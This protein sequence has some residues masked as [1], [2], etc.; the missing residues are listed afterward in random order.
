MIL[1]KLHMKKAKAHFLWLLLIC[2]IVLME[3]PSAFS[4]S[5]S[6]KVPLNFRNQPQGRDKGTLRPGE[7]FLILKSTANWVKIKRRNGQVGW[8]YRKYVR[9]DTPSKKQSTKSEAPESDF[10]A[11]KVVKA[12]SLNVRSGA[13]SNYR[14]V[15][16][17]TNDDSVEVLS[18]NGGWSKIRTSNGQVGYVFTQYLSDMASDIEDTESIKTET[19]S[20]TQGSDENKETATAE[21]AIEEPAEEVIAESRTK[22]DSTLEAGCKDCLT[23]EARITGPGR[24]LLDIGSK[25]Y[26]FHSKEQAKAEKADGKY[27]PLIARNCQVSSTSKYGMRK[28]PILGTRLMHTG[29]DI[30]TGGVATPIRAPMAGKIISAGR[31]GGYGNQIKMKLDNGLVISFSHLSRFGIKKGQRVQAG[32]VVGKTGSTGRSTGIHL[33]FEVEKNGARVDPLKYFKKSEMCGA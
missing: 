20:E 1:S 33:H 13:G 10:K 11:N 4:Q 18:E 9:T 14:K 2:G 26:E 31:A 32:A 27:V 16:H 17:L 15:G 23:Q 30:R 6:T 28:H 25:V 7:K 29:Q 5:A 24:E 21:E 8:V 12:S 3:A 22:D 19:Q